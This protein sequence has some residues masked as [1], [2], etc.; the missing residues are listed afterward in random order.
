MKIDEGGSGNSSKTAKE[1]EKYWKKF[2]QG[3]THSIQ[4]I[5]YERDKKIIDKVYKQKGYKIYT[6][7]KRTYIGFMKKDRV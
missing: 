6:K 5:V 7:P 3:E 1:K 4:N 2:F